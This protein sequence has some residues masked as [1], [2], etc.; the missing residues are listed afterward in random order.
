MMRIFVAVG[1]L[2]ESS[3]SVQRLA[4]PAVDVALRALHLGMQAG[5]RIACLR[6]IELRLA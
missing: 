2:V 1:T 4:V 6:V 3:A 5:Q